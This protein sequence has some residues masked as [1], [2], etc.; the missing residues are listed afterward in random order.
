M[1]TW[2]MDKEINSKLKKNIPHSNGTTSANVFENTRW[3]EA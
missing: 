3:P 2:N 1:N